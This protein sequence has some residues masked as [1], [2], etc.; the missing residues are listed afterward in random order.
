MERYRAGGEQE[1]LNTLLLRYGP[2]IRGFVGRRALS[3][4]GADDLTQ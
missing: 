4:A 2:A 1:R 3:A